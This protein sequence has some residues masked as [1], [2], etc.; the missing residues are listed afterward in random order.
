[1]IEFIKTNSFITKELL[2]TGE[3]DGSLL[4]GVTYR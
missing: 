4:K 2:L 1:M 3:E